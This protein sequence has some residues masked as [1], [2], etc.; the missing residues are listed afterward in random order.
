MEFAHADKKRT[1]LIRAERNWTRREYKRR[2]LT[3]KQ[4][5][6]C[7]SSCK[8][9]ESQLAARL[10]G[11]NTLA[12]D[13]IFQ[14]IFHGRERFAHRTSSSSLSSTVGIVIGT[15][16]VIL[17]TLHTMQSKN[18]LYASMQFLIMVLVREISSKWGREN[19]SFPLSLRGMTRKHQQPFPS[20]IRQIWEQEK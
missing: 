12:K 17:E 8:L 9:C 7:N 14:G 16:N 19:L 10:K 3:V 18:R 1:V 5:T 13:R 6:A 2:S 15:G 11:Q 4:R 20:S